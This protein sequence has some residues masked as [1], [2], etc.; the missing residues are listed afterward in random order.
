[1]LPV[2]VEENPLQDTDRASRRVRRDIEARIGYF[3]DHPEEVGERL[4]ELDREWCIERIMDIGTAAA[5]FAGPLLAMGTRRWLMLPAVLSGFLLQHAIQGRCAPASL[6]RR[7]GFRTAAEIG[8]ERYA[9]KAVRGD[10]RNLSL[11][12][13]RS[14]QERSRQ[15]LRVVRL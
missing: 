3:A 13:I 4:A 2:I 8:Q 14:A 9:L 7:M 1:M 5:S 6:L 15:A 10:F 12:G 11:P